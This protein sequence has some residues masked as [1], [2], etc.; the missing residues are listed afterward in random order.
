MGLSGKMEER[1]GKKKAPLQTL[2]EAGGLSPQVRGLV[3]ATYEKFL[4]IHTV[5]YYLGV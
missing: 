3:T 1:R 4:D 5:F 2:P